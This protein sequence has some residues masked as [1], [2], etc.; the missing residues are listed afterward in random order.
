[1]LEK[2]FNDKQNIET[3]YKYGFEFDF[4]EEMDVMQNLT[5]VPHVAIYQKD[6]RVT[7]G[8]SDV[9]RGLAYLAHYAERLMDQEGFD[10]IIP[11]NQRIRIKPKKNH[12]YILVTD[13]LVKND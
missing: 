12:H 4:G 11:R 10:K 7:I 2:A 6:I 3:I 8:I 1:M 5:F 13:P 9:S